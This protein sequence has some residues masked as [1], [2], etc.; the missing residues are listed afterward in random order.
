MITK[1]ASI[2]NWASVTPASTKMYRMKSGLKEVVSQSVLADAK[3][4][5][6]T[7]RKHG[8]GLNI[9]SVKTFILWR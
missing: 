2:G 4:T 9:N 3:S 7:G 6:E 1:I 5:N 8:I